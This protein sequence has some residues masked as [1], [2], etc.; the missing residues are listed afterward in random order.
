MP[1]MSGMPILIRQE[2]SGKCPQI[3]QAAENACLLRVEYGAIKG[4]DD[5]RQAG[6][7]A[8]GR[9]ERERAARHKL[10]WIVDMNH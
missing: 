7:E 4:D 5:P 2:N 1:R 3:R 10:I 8:D 9:Y 6:S